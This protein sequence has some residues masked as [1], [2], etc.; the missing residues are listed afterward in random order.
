MKG[1]YSPLFIMVNHSCMRPL[2][3]EILKERDV[4]F[5]KLSLH[6]CEEYCM[7]NIDHTLSLILIII[8]SLWH[9]TLF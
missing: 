9:I 4:Q 8:C 7:N 6:L 5:Y 2:V 3:P 1:S